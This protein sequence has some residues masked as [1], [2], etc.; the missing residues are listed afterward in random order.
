M[1]D[2]LLFVHPQW[3]IIRIGKTAKEMQ[4]VKHAA[5]CK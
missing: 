2:K 1:I 3:Q 4:E 5:A